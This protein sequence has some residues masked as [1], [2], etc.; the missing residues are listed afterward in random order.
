MR[1]SSLRRRWSVVAASALVC[2][3]IWLVG[4]AV[5]AAASTASANNDATFRTSFSNTTVTLINLTADIQMN[6]GS[7]VFFRNGSSP[8]A[9][10]VVNG[11]GHTITAS[12]CN[13]QVILNSGKS[14]LTLDDVTI[15][16]GN[17]SSTC[18]I[19]GAGV[20]SNGNIDLIDAQVIGNTATTTGNDSACAPQGGGIAVTSGATV[21]LVRSTVADNHAV[22]TSGCGFAIGGGIY[23]H[24]S[25]VTLE[26]STV[27]NNTTSA[28]SNTIAGGI[29]AMT[30]TAVYST[31]ARNSAANGA[32]IEFENTSVDNGA[33]TLTSFATV[34]ALPLGGGG[35]CLAGTVNKTFT[36]EGY[37]FD[38]DGSCG[39]GSATGDQSNAGDPGLGL[40]AN[41]GGPTQTLLPGNGSPLI[42]AVATADCSH[43]GASTIVPLTDQRSL[44]RPAGAGCEIGAV[45]LQPATTTTTSGS[46]TTTT[47]AATPVEVAPAFTG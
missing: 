37:S 10:L 42:D 15:T 4:A 31:I 17:Y 29:E 20:Q 21:S 36:S 46:T 30:V 34:I 7:G 39:F 47:P 1:T 11:H 35:N 40:I 44:P 26:N 27:S 24:N 45:E 16:G 3:C 43:D 22:C 28:E 41:N 6:C 18:S 25:T 13:K 32:N 9:D 33:V 8:S 38:D 14:L 23:A 19:G 12:G 5:P 2:G